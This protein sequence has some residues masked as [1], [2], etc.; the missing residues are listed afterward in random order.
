[1]RDT[2]GDAPPHS[3]IISLSFEHLVGYHEVHREFPGPRHFPSLCETVQVNPMPR[4]Y[5]SRLLEAG[6]CQQLTTC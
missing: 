2:S 3:F 4:C 5:F 6:A 1:M